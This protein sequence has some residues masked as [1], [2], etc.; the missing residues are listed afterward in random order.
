LPDGELAGVAVSSSRFL[1]LVARDGSWRLRDT[2]ERSERRG[3]FGIPLEAGALVSVSPDG[4]SVCAFS[5]ERL[6][7]M[8]VGAEGGRTFSLA[9]M[10][11]AL[12]LHDDGISLVLGH[13]CR[14]GQLWPREV[15]AVWYDPDSRDRQKTAGPFG[16]QLAGDGL[17]LLLSTDLVFMTA[18]PA[19]DGS[20]VT[21]WDMVTLK[22]TAERRFPAKVRLLCL[23]SDCRLAAVYVPT[24]S[25]CHVVDTATAD[26]ADRWTLPVASALDASAIRSAG[27]LLATCDQRG[28][29]SMFRALGS[30]QSCHSEKG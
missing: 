1:L 8:A 19:G 14:F 12:R 21:L 23:Q 7:L 25:V 2:V 16:E 6:E 17:E 5:R 18:R 26:L 28:S 13:G 20:V 4:R 10:A 3:R 27:D 30:A 9:M 29:V 15:M 22:Q 24:H 11:R